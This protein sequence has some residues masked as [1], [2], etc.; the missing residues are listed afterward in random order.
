ML[1]QLRVLLLQQRV[2]LQINLVDIVT[3]CN[4]KYSSRNTHYERRGHSD[5]I[6]IREH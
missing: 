3:I 4:I 2:Q 6:I 5:S 1:L